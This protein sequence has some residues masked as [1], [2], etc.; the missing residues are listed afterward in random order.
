MR[1]ATVYPFSTSG[2]LA[3][4]YREVRAASERLC[5]PLEIEDYGLQSTPEA[6][7]IKWHL[8]HT[9]WFFETF[10]V[11]RFTKH[12]RPFHDEFRWIF[13]SYYD[14]VGE[15]WPR[16]ERGLI[17]RPTVAEVF[18]YR[19]RIDEEISM[20]L[21][22][23]PSSEVASL[24]KLGLQHEQQHQELIVTDLKHAWSKNPL[25]PPYR[26]EN[27]C[28]GFEP[29]DDS[30]YASEPPDPRWL[31][32]SE[33]LAW[34]GHA[35]RGFAFDNESPRHRRFVAGF[36]IA[37]RLATNG[38]YER[39]IDDQGYERS[40]WWLSDGWQTC[41]EERWQSP[42]YW[43]QRDGQWTEFTLGGWRDLDRSAP[44]CHLSYFEA[45]AFARWSGARLPTEA[46]W[47]VAAAAAPVAGAFSETGEFQ[48]R[49]L[50]V[51]DDG[52][53]FQ[54]Y[55][56]VWQWTSSP[57]AA[58]P[59]YRPSAGALGEYNGK[60]MCNQF[61]LRG[62]SCATPRTHARL[63]YRNFFAAAT[64]WQFAGIRLA[65]DLS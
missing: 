17:A 12:Y 42:L 5:E 30:L 65:K 19:A 60:F 24:I 50:R 8:A 33:G 20:L 51:I 58:Y 41:R 37:D 36:Q 55:G 39:F 25:A 49:A 14:A 48:P 7:P 44:V 54:L 2:Q 13:N 15:R 61:V 21:D 29:I 47:E 56:D 32:Y 43:K 62:A 22:E 64:R 31:A 34:I 27:L 4:A 1:L 52:P 9:T 26:L 18:R 40:E 59:G 63:T 28:E 10:I 45:D 3:A 46:E 23:S 11:A 35:G 53:L 6:S 38:D 16:G 57:Y